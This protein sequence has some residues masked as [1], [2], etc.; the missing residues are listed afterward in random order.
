MGAALPLSFEALPEL[1]VLSLVS[2]SV[3]VKGTTTP[4]RTYVKK[5]SSKRCAVFY[6]NNSKHTRPHQLAGSASAGLP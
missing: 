1:T 6:R 2:C 4:I 5:K 3:P